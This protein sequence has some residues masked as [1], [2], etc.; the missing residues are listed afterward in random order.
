MFLLTVLCH[1][2]WSG[3]LMNRMA[4]HIYTSVLRHLVH[5]YVLPFFFFFLKYCKSLLIPVE[6]WEEYSLIQ[7]AL[8]RYAVCTLCSV[9]NKSLLHS[10]SQWCVIDTR[11]YSWQFCRAL[12][13]SSLRQAFCFFSPCFFKGGP[14]VNKTCAMFPF[15]FWLFLVLFPLPR[16]S[17]VLS[18]NNYSLWK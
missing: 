14:S 3:N 4:C 17:S 18:H 6:K 16:L 5:A 7:E 1:L 10:W 9:N 11:L 13:T 12:Q 2:F 15:D 8:C